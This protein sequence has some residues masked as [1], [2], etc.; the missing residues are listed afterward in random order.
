[1]DSYG[2]VRTLYVDKKKCIPY[3]NIVSLFN[4]KIIPISQD[5]NVNRHNHVAYF[6]HT[7]YYTVC[8]LSYVPHRP[9]MRAGAYP[10]PISC[11]CLN[12]CT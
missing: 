8:C 1:M 11:T 2:Q 5:D 3:I 4:S 7:Y 9:P 12:P 6:E 10:T